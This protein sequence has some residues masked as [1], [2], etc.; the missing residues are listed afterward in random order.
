[1]CKQIL[2]ALDLIFKFHPILGSNNP[3][4][5]RRNRAGLDVNK[6]LTMPYQFTRIMHR[7]LSSMLLQFYRT[8]Y[9]Y[10]GICQI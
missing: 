9:S 7:R 1:M 5:V 6:L 4:S 3:V 8:E 10:V 2:L